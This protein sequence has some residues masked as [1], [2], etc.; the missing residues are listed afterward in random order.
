MAASESRELLVCPT[1]H[2]VFRTGYRACP[3]DGTRLMA[4][5]TDPLIGTEIS[6]RYLIEA[7]LG[8]GGL[9]RV[10]RARHTRMSRRYALKILYGDVAY[11]PKIRARFANEAEAA[12]RLSHPNVVGVVDFGETPEGLLYLAMDLAEGGS[13][14]DLIAEHGRLPPYQ[15]I[16]MFRDIVLG[17]AHAHE[18]GLIHRDLKPENIIIERKGGQPR[19]VDFGLALLQEQQTARVTTG[20]MVIGT[21][22][23]M[24]PEQATGE[25]I[26]QRT[27]LFSLG[28]VLYEM[29]A[30]LLPFE[31]PALE[32]ARM[33]LTM[34]PPPFAARVPGLVVEPGLEALCMRLLAKR[35]KDR[36][37]TAQAVLAMIDRLG[38]QGATGKLD[39][40]L[41]WIDGATGPTELVADPL[42]ATAD[43]EVHLG[44]APPPPPTP[45]ALTAPPPPDATAATSP[46]VFIPR[47]PPPPRAEPFDPDQDRARAAPLTTHEIVASVRGRSRGLAI[48]LAVVGVAAAAVITWRLAR[49]PAS[50]PAAA[51]R[52]PAD[53]P[54]VVAI[55]DVDAAPADAA[56]ADGLGVSPIDAG[57][58]VPLPDA[59][60]A[61]TR[62]VD[63]AP[64]RLVDAAPR[65]IIDAP[66]APPIDAAVAR[67]PIDAGVPRPRPVDAGVAKP[68][69]IDA[70]P[71]APAVI[72]E[73]VVKSQY[74]KVGTAIDALERAGKTAAAKGLRQR[75]FDLPYLDAINKPERRAEF[76]SRLRLLER[77]V[78]RAQ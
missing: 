60:V 73:S 45:R 42:A 63:A 53:A 29:L 62:V 49:S 32:V 24:A 58:V 33:N 37:D 2:A 27:D 72:T 76:M 4:T 69:P 57:V 9:G 12:S 61:S 31:G 68:P 6:G 71:A 18:R 28:L 16:R 52:A 47:T 43:D 51:V 46:A 25:A 55:V 10:Y 20:G 67:P 77:D 78:T 50:D 38:P 64:T 17:L 41:T 36:P 1:C 34:P 23:Y 40:K 5:T 75:W 59:S 65:R 3:H 13:L 56:P 8:D 39:Q 15:V 66:A 48:G 14:A 26:D 19:I 70:G 11:D 54:S 30:G 7:L 22:H 44:D 21:P 74:R 35:P